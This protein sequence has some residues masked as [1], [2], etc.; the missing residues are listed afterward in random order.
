MPTNLSLHLSYIAGY[1]RVGGI[2]V[3]ETNIVV[4]CHIPSCADDK[5]TFLAIVYVRKTPY[6]CSRKH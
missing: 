3:D 1:K 2:L 4:V 5:Y 6:L